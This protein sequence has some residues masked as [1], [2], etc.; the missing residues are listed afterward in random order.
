[1]LARTRCVD[2]SFGQ[3]TDGVHGNQLSFRVFS[4]EREFV[5]LLFR[6]AFW[7]ARGLDYSG[8]GK[9]VRLLGMG[10]SGDG[11]GN[12]AGLENAKKE[13]RIK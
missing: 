10:V 9:S 4:F 8:P 13:S 12:L 3:E 6:Q 5:R 11:R 2:F 7:I 1:M